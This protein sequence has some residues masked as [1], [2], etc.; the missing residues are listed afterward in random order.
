LREI[1][2][3]SKKNSFIKVKGYINLREK[4]EIDTWNIV[5]KSNLSQ[6]NWIKIFKKNGYMGNY[7][8]S[9]F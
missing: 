1:V 2:R 5:A 3:V 4:K 7:Q 8:F 6:K 9:K